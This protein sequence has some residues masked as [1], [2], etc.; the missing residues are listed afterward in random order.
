MSM[1]ILMCSVGGA[2]SRTIEHVNSF[3]IRN[4]YAT[5]KKLD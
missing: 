1:M 2:N 5:S 3:Q 4:E